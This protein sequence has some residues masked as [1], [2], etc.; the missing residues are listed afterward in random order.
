LPRCSLSLRDECSTCFNNQHNSSFHIHVFCVIS[1]ETADVSLNSF[2]HLISLKVKRCVLGD[3]DWILK[4]YLD[5]FLLQ[6]VNYRCRS[7]IPY[8][9]ALQISVTDN[10][11]SWTF[12][13]LK[14]CKLISECPVEN[15]LLLFI[16]LFIWSKAVSATKLNK[17]PS[18]HQP[19]QV[20][21][22][23]HVAVKISAP[24]IME[25]IRSIE[26]N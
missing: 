13:C 25:T 16:Y 26:N 12:G 10:T 1:T 21:K 4:H 3:G 17:I 6:R 20:A 23:T 18:D 9:T 11:F 15:N 5:E 2:N 19:H 24:I 7:N 14:V 22:E 8:Q